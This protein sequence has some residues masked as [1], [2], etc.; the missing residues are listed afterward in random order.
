MFQQHWGSTCAGSNRKEWVRTGAVNNQ[1]QAALNAS[2]YIGIQASK[3]TGIHKLMFS[4]NADCLG[5]EARAKDLE[6]T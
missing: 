3:H 2:R 1:T 4:R 6:K 5:S